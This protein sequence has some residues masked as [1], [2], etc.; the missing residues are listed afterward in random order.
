MAR[1]RRFR[2]VRMRAHVHPRHCEERSDDPS[3]RAA[4]ATPGVQ[5]A[6][7]RRAKA[8]AIHHA[9]S[10]Y[11]DCFA[12]PVIRRRFAP[13]GWLAMTTWRLRLQR[14]QKPYRLAGRRRHDLA[15]PH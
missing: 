6:E 15:L 4:Q 13:T 12:E 1:L 9:A 7:S 10:G 14:L 3:T 2:A 5:S 11:M 8:D